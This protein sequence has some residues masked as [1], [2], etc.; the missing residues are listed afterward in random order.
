MTCV[1]VEFQAQGQRG[2][3]GQPLLSGGVEIPAALQLL[4]HDSAEMRI[5]IKI[6][7]ARSPDPAVWLAF[8]PWFQLVGGMKSEPCKFIVKLILIREEPLKSG[9]VVAGDRVV[10]PKQD[11]IL[12]LMQRQPA[13][14]VKK[15]SEEFFLAGDLLGTTVARGH[16]DAQQYEAGRASKDDAACPPRKSDW[17]GLKLFGY[18]H[19][20]RNENP[21]LPRL[22]G[23]KCGVSVVFESLTNE[24]GSRIAIG[25]SENN[26]LVAT[27]TQP[28]KNLGRSRLSSY[29]DVQGENACLSDFRSL[30]TTRRLASCRKAL[31]CPR[32]AGEASRRHLLIER[33]EDVGRTFDVAEPDPASW[34]AER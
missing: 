9:N 12:A 24:V 8:A 1:L 19:S 30:A 18:R 27:P 33:R 25:L 28:A 34:A 22:N 10:V 29:C 13:D 11:E 3:I 15:G 32:V 31:E 7:N 2:V 21:T 6:A 20:R 17:E 23:R 16:V 26:D 14:A 4:A 5:V